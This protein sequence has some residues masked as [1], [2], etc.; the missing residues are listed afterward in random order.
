MFDSLST[1]IIVHGGHCGIESSK[2]TYILHYKYATVQE[3]QASPAGHVVDRNPNLLAQSRDWRL[4]VTAVFCE[5]SDGGA[6][7]KGLDNLC[8]RSMDCTNQ[9]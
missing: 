6:Y 5:L 1:G 7:R 9:L 4:F 3:M 8:S 2:T